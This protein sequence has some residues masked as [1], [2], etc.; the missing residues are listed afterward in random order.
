MQLDFSLTFLIQ[1][2]MTYLVEVRLSMCMENIL[3][4]HWEE[5]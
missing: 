3:G 5:N 1:T 4:H 2:K